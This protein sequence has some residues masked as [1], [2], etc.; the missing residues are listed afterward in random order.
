MKR[1]LVIQTASI[2]DVILVT[3][4]V[5]ALK[6]RWPQ[7]S[8]NVLVKKGIEGVLAHNPHLNEVLTW[9]KA[10]K[11]KD[12]A[13]LVGTVRANNYTA[14]YCVQRHF[15]MGLLTVLSRAPLTVGFESSPW[16]RAF[17]KTAPHEF[18]ENWHEVDRNFRLLKDKPVTLAE[19]RRPQLFPSADDYRVVAPLQ[20]KPYVCIAPK[21]LWATKELPKEKWVHLIHTLRGKKIYLLGGAADR[22]ACEDV[23]R[24]AQES[25]AFSSDDA[26]EVESLAGQLSLLQSAALM[27]KADMNYVNDSTPM[28]LASAMNA[29]V[30]AFFCST[31]P[32]FGFTPLSDRSF[33]VQSGEALSCRPCGIHGRPKCPEGHFKCG[34]TIESEGWAI[35]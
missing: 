11:W 18:R 6:E 16:A 22:D 2:G 5:R 17:S 19:H 1:I 14:V 29:P 20:T 23:I 27:A 24:S 12:F 8:V 13:R 35:Q 10:K 15:S 30:T 7:A 25:R 33:V 9:D 4:L 3:P 34:T 26:P 31:I 32:D 21:S 28:H